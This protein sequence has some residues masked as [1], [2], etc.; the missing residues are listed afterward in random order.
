MTTPIGDPRPAGQEGPAGDQREAGESGPAG[1]PRPA[2]SNE[3]TPDAFD[4]SAH[5]VSQVQDY[6]DGAD[7]TERERVLAAERAGKDRATITG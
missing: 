4:P 5:T 3:G 1:D 2:G 6:L 7:P